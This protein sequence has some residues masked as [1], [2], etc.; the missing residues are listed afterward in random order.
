MRQPTKMTG[1]NSL[2]ERFRQ[3]KEKF[4]AF[5]VYVKVGWKVVKLWIRSKLNSFHKWVEV[6]RKKGEEMKK[7]GRRDLKNALNNEKN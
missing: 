4:W 2:K 7:K 5:L 6:N 1:K 3:S